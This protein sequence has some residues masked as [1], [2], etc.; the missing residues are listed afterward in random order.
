MIE[1]NSPHLGKPPAPERVVLLLPSALLKKVDQLVG[2]DA[3]NRSEALRSL[4][5]AGLR[6]EAK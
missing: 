2:K 5:A 3:L 1:Q 6:Q 4:I